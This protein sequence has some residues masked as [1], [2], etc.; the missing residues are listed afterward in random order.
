MKGF[1]RELKKEKRRERVRTG[2]KPVNKPSRNV[3]IRRDLMWGS[4]IVALL[5][6]LI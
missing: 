5:R 1:E 3:R 4:H 2:E 6:C